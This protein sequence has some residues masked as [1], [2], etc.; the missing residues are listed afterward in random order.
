MANAMIN[1]NSFDIVISLINTLNI[2]IEDLYNYYKNQ[3]INQEIIKES[4]EEVSN[5]E[6]INEIVKEDNKKVSK[7]HQ[8]TFKKCWGDY[9]SD[10]ESDNEIEKNK[11]VKS[12]SDIVKNN[13]NTKPEYYET[14]EET[15]NEDEIEIIKNDSEIIKNNDNEIDNNGFEEV[16]RKNKNN[17][18]IKINNLQ[19]FL[20]FMK[21]T[22]K[23]EYY[24]N[25]NAHCFHTYQGTLCNDIKKCKKIHIQ[26]CMNGSTCNKKKCTYIHSFNMPDNKSKNNFINTM[27]KYNQ[28]KSKKR[29]NV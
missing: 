17:S 16:K 5:K 27:E 21:N 25:P 19:E 7:L 22:P 10:E 24:I 18:C 28:I 15:D 3:N 13:N 12:Y 29:V 4:I 8:L 6:I 9:E 1:Q 23:K 20:D 14:D 11:N 26:R 2:N